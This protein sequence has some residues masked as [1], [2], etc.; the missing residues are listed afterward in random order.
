MRRWWGLLALCA[1]NELF[2]ID[3]TH[4]LGRIDAQYFDAMVDAPFSCPPVGTAP[5]FLTSPQ[6]FVRQ[7]CLLYQYS[8]DADLAIADCVGMLSQGTIGGPLAPIGDLASSST[9]FR[10]SAWLDPEGDQLI[11][12]EQQ[13]AVPAFVRYMHAGGDHWTRGGTLIWPGSLL[14]P[15]SASTPTRGVP[16]RMLALDNG[17]YLDE[18]IDDG[19]DTLQVHRRYGQGELGI[20][21]YEGPMLSADGLRMVVNGTV[22]DGMGNVHVAVWYTD[23]PSIDDDFRAFTELPD[24]P[25]I[26]D[27]FLRDDCGRV[28]F[29][30]IGS[31]WYVQHP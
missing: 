7:E 2:G 31:V 26:P 23:R 11:V 20:Y 30:G 6:Q 3:K 1:C 21:N 25:S 10:Q 27:P 13:S 12:Q 17:G 22:P 5:V 9:V 18:M 4:A 16:R 28:Y 14:A 15:Y 8:S 19:S 24:V 29:S